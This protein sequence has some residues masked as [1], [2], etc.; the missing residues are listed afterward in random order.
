MADSTKDDWLIRYGDV[1]RQAEADYRTGSL[2]DQE[3]N[4]IINAIDMA[5]QVGSAP[6]AALRLSVKKVTCCAR[7]GTCTS[8][9]AMMIVID[10]DGHQTV[11]SVCPVCEVKFDPD[12]TAYT[13]P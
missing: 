1:Y 9:G 12:L 4:A 11:P 6:S 3:L 8:C 5:P 13:S 10:A 7:M 2:D